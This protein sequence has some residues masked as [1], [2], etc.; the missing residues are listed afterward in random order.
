MTWLK[1]EN[2]SKSKQQKWV[3]DEHRRTFITWLRE[4]IEN[5]LKED[6]H[7]ISDSLKWIAHTPK[8]YV[9]KHNAY[10]I[11]GYRFNT[12]SLDDVRSMQ[13]S[14]ISIIANTTQFSSAKDQKPVSSDIT[15]YGVIQEIWELDYHTFRIAV[16]KCDWVE[17]NNGLR[18]DEDGFTLVDLQ[19]KGYKSDPFILASQA[20][21]VFYIQDPKD[22]R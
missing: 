7:N 10:V 22:K 1:K 4:K 16:F 20:K 9:I 18:I 8:V 2:P 13:N 15:Y 21:Q 19:R 6:K 12:K 11:N 14:G 3:Y 5:Q 17:Y